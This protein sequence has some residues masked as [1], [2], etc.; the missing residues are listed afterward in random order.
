ML[1]ILEIVR[2][3]NKYKNPPNKDMG[4]G[5][6][7]A[8]DKMKEWRLKNPII[9]EVGNYVKVIIPHSTLARPEELILEFL[10]DNE[11][12]TNEIAR[13]VTGVKSGDIIKR[14]FHKLRGDN[15]IERVPG[16]YGRA[17]AWRLKHDEK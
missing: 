2:I 14:N 17:S 3:L 13:D 11:M 5:L 15:L 6:N 4:E 8:F 12:I 7:T 16:L 1:D 9:T 10:E